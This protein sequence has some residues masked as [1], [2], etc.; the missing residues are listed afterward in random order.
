MTRGP[1]PVML[2]EQASEAR[3][4]LQGQSCPL[5][6]ALSFEDRPV[7]EETEVYTNRRIGAQAAA[8]RVLGRHLATPNILG[9]WLCVA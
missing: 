2:T 3:P 6:T 5:R 9:G 7:S 4:A 1:G 8:S